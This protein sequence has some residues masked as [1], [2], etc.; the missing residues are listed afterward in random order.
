MT[1]ILSSENSPQKMLAP[2]WQIQVVHKVLTGVD[3]FIESQTDLACSYRE[4]VRD[5]LKLKTFHVLGAVYACT[6][7]TEIPTFLR[8]QLSEA[9]SLLERLMGDLPDT[10]DDL[11]DQR[12]GPERT[13][14]LHSSAIAAF[15]GNLNDYIEFQYLDNRIGIVINNVFPALRTVTQ[16]AID[17][18]L[19]RISNSEVEDFLREQGA[20][21]IRRYSACLEVMHVQDATTRYQY[22][23]AFLGEEQSKDR[24]I[25]KVESWLCDPE[26]YYLAHGTTLGTFGLLLEATLNPELTYDDIIAVS[27]F[28]D[29][30]VG[31]M[32]VWV[33]D[34]LDVKEDTERNDPN[35]FTMISVGEL[36]TTLRTMREEI[37][38]DTDIKECSKLEQFNHLLMHAY[39]QRYRTLQQAI[40]NHTNIH[41]QIIIDMLESYR[42][43][44]LASDPTKIL[45]FEEALRI[46]TSITS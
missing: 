4:K 13:R 25:G 18:I 37:L 40:P 45:L 31:L 29:Q 15:T 8:I 2:F 43:L 21:M 30:V 33:D 38:T 14:A 26:I 17:Q 34:L 9:I 19:S 22:A 1:Q 16:E 39:M 46:V 10:L 23:L 28:Y 24:V 12:Q 44:A 36:N 20:E 35:L 42:D 7:P 27:R 6:K 11:S 5:S 41:H 3:E 32:H